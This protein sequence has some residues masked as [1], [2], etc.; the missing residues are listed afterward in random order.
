ML[1]KPLLSVFQHTMVFFFSLF[2]EIPGDAKTVYR[3]RRKKTTERLLEGFTIKHRWVSKGLI[4]NILLNLLSV[5]N[6]FAFIL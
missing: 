2:K 1:P 6:F 5:F 4:L 3:R